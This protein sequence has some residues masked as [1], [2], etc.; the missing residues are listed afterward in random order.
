[1]AFTTLLLSL[2]TVA[3]NAQQ[4]SQKL[5]ADETAPAVSPVS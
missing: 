1:M 3:T 2:L 4:S 5:I